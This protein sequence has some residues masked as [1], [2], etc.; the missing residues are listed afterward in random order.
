MRPTGSVRSSSLAMMFIS[1][2]LASADASAAESAGSG[3]AAGGRLVAVNHK[4]GLHGQMLVSEPDPDPDSVAFGTTNPSALAT[5]TQ[6]YSDGPAVPCGTKNGNG[7]HSGDESDLAVSSRRLNTDSSYTVT[8][9]FSFSS[10]S[11]SCVCMSD[12]ANGYG[13]L[14]GAQTYEAASFTDTLDSSKTV[15]G[16]TATMCGVSCGCNNMQ[17]TVGGVYVGSDTTTYNCVCSGQDYLSFDATS[18]L[19]AG[20][21]DSYNIGGT[22]EIIMTIDGNYAVSAIAVTIYYRDEQPSSEPT[23][24]PQ[25]TVTPAPTVLPTVAPT[26]THKPTTKPTPVP[27]PFPTPSPSPIP[28]LVP[29]TPIPT[30]DC[31]DA[32]YGV[33]DVTG[34]CYECP[35]GRY[36]DNSTTSHECVWCAVGTYQSASGQTS[37][38]DCAEG[39][40]SYADRT[41]CGACDKGE[42][43]YN[44][45]AC[46]SC[47]FGRYAPTA[48][49]DE[50]LLCSEG[51]YT[52][53]AISASTCSGCDAGK[54]AAE[55]SVNCTECEAGTYSTSKSETCTDCEAGTYS[56]STG[57]GSCTSCVPG[58][59][60]ASTKQTACEQCVA[61]TI[62]PANGATSCIEC[63]SGT[64]ATAG[65][66]S[67]TKCDG[68]SYSNTTGGAGSCEQCTSGRYSTTASADCELCAG[69]KYSS[70]G[71]AACDT[72][73]A[74]TASSAGD[75]SCEMCAAG[76]F[77]AAGASACSACVAGNY[78][79]KN[80]S[81]TCTPCPSG[82]YEALGAATACEAC[83]PGKIAATAGSTACAACASGTYAL[84]ASSACTK[85]DAG[86]YSLKASSNCTQCGPGT[87][88][89]GAASLCVVC[90]VG[91][92]AP[93]KG[94]ATRCIDCAGGTFQNE[95]GSTS[96]NNCTIG[97]YAVSTG[98][99]ACDNCAA[100]QY[101]DEAGQLYCEKCSS[102]PKFGPEYWSEEGAFECDQCVLGY[103][104]DGQTAGDYPDCDGALETCAPTRCAKCPSGVECRSSGITI[105]SLVMKPG[106][107]RFTETSSDVRECPYEKNCKFPNG[108]GEGICIK[109]AVGPLCGKCDDRYYLR[110]AVA[111][112]VACITSSSWYIGPLVGLLILIMGLVVLYSQ[113]ARI[114][115]FKKKYTQ[116]IE[117]FSFRLAA[118]FVTLQIIMLLQENRKAVGG[119]PIPRPYGNFVANLSFLAL[120]I[121]QFLPF[122]CAYGKQMDHFEALVFNTTIPLS[123][124]AF[125]M[126]IAW[127]MDMKEGRKGLLAHVKRLAETPEQKA[128]RE[129]KKAK[130]NRDLA[131]A[132][133]ASGKNLSEDIKPTHVKQLGAYFMQAALLILPATSLRIAK[134]VR[135]DYFDCPTGLSGK[136][137][138]FESCG[139]FDNPAYGYLAAD[140]TI[141][142]LDSEFQSMDRYW[143]MFT[144]SMCMIFIYPIG[145]PLALWVSLYRIR[146]KLNPPG[147]HEHTA[148][149]HRKDDF[150]G[151][152]LKEPIAQFATHYRPHVW[153][154]EVYALL[155]RLVLTSLALACPD[156]GSTT[157]FVLSVSLITL[158]IEKESQP[159]VN[160]YLTAFTYMLHWQVILVIL[161][162]LLLD[163]EMTSGIGAVFISVSLLIVNIG[164][165]AI[166]LFDTR[167]T[168]KKMNQ[169]LHSL[170]R[171]NSNLRRQTLVSTSEPGGQED[172]GHSSPIHIEDVGHEVGEGDD[173]IHRV[174]SD[175]VAHVI[176]EGGV[177]KMVPVE[178][179]PT[180]RP[181]GVEMTDF[182]PPIG[183]PTPTDTVETTETAVANTETRG[184]EATL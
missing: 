67:C 112:C 59:Y 118:C 54:Y 34:Q 44:D 32:G 129:A 132:R 146:D 171:A 145:I 124:F 18:S 36:D 107:F 100:G 72:C 144:Y 134:S 43:A 6:T 45:T 175:D 110:D 86:T 119:K 71:S 87:Y 16:I 148:I 56:A 20:E 113:K 142:C 88:S 81:D 170:D 21:A 70:T 26:M 183:L 2:L 135:C 53:V 178:A 50:C 120:D 141:D 55:G 131:I 48:Q 68:G 140:Y 161:F 58:Y 155:R 74:G 27:S 75:G 122:S 69:G 9:T 136:T 108:T 10:S 147:M 23:S 94:Q 7:A 177:H 64:Y 167:E 137:L 126:L 41:N 73:V 40:L 84:A 117:G 19:S 150:D 4:P 25:P 160:P 3:H 38:D 49:E 179:I 37:C 114:L 98:A 102:S 109:G 30:Q 24:T 57:E 79:T 47:P 63:D 125:V 180:P 105:E 82:Y 157:I 139:E 5:S 103:Y 176:E 77:S 133:S 11:T 85:C 96:C 97:R 61:G 28:T 93:G 13:Y 128:A 151:L 65:A 130:S 149:K 104:S 66:S 51:F 166:V 165:I 92:K 127:L 153:Y 116:K 163:A 31:T 164:M 138:D 184:A 99:K 8:T 101:T 62:A 111:Q 1:A 89:L 172:D 123:V 143:S 91:K 121:I 78:N 52:G 83:T 168:D 35:A 17:L 15:T 181:D 152:L 39:T 95:N 154:Y 158:V 80:G 33:S 76:F 90:E 169:V 12:Y 14:T 173:D 156:L 46:E 42:Y 29:S 182:V 60:Q 174:H 22:N 159:H 162:T 106:F 115:E